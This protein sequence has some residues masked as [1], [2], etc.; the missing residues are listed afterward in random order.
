MR[1]DGRGDIDLSTGPL[2]INLPYEAVGDSQAASGHLVPKGQAPIRT[3][4]TAKKDGSNS[5]SPLDSPD[6]QRIGDRRELDGCHAVQ[7]R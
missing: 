1:M 4:I 7:S 6:C 2:G 5:S 3:A